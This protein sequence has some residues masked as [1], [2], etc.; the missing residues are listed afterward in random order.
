MLYNNS[1]S[2]QEE[3]LFKRE[4]DI[5]TEPL[6]KSQTDIKVEPI[7]NSAVENIPFVEPE[8]NRGNFD[9]L[10]KKGLHE[11]NLNA[12]STHNPTATPQDINTEVLFKSGIE[13]ISI[14]KDVTIKEET[15]SFYEPVK[16]DYIEE[17]VLFKTDDN[18]NPIVE[19]YSIFEDEVLQKE[20]VADF[21]EDN[22]E[23]TDDYQLSFDDLTSVV[24][25]GFVE[26]A[27]VD[28]VKKNF[29]QKMLEQEPIL[30]DYY[31]QLKN[32]LLLYKNVKSRVS[33]TCDTFNTGRT[34]LAKISTS[35]KTLKLYL[36]L[37]YE[38]VEPRLKCKYAGEKKAYSQV[39]V[40]LRVRSPRSFKNAKYLIDILAEKHGLVENPKSVLVDTEQILQDKLN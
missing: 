38:T 26:P 4:N 29:S 3:T 16:P 2:I 19:N 1:M 14:D 18:D 34:V 39:P 9:V 12:N 8:E 10:F 17:E 24:G 15:L 6:F 40:F 7:K 25:E 28:Y 37:D 32:V 27:K 23:E 35:G 36:N 20:E 11:E 5:Q 31:N 13:D 21:E 30:L 33:N 22:E